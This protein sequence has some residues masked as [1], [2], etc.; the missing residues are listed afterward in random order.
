M[1]EREREVPPSLIENGAP[2]RAGPKVGDADEAGIEGSADNHLPGC[3]DWLR[4]AW[5]RS[6]VET[7]RIERDKTG[8][9]ELLEQPL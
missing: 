3:Q 8:S 1:G 2:S 5:C 4:R 7:Q 6:V 9:V